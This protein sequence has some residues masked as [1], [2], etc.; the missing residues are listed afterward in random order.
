MIKKQ[1]E[2]ASRHD[3]IYLLG[4]NSSMKHSVTCT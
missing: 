4:W 3:E 1:N 2:Q